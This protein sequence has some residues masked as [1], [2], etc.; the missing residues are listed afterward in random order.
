M[1]SDKHTGKAKLTLEQAILAVSE[2]KHISGRALAKK[3][4][5][6]HATVNNVRSGNTWK[7]KLTLLGFST[8][9]KKND[10]K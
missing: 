10:P 2:L 9:D 4:G 1:K 5:V 7:A 6:S 8:K 3:W